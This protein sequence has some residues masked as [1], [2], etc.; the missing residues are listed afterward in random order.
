[1]LVERKVD[2][3]AGNRP[4]KSASVKAAVS[5]PKSSAKMGRPAKRDDADSESVNT[6]TEEG[7]TAYDDAVFSF[8][9]ENGG[10][11]S[12]NQIRSACGGNGDQCRKSTARLL[13]SSRLGYEGVARGT[14]Y[15]VL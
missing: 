15:F 3:S 12:A 2:T 4:V 5:S 8:V 9:Q 1:M 10:R 7:R 14:K 13:E 11:V 6:R